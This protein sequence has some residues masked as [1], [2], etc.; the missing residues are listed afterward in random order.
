[1]LLFIFASLNAKCGTIYSYHLNAA[2]YAGEHVRRYAAGPK[3]VN[4][5]TYSSLT[6][7][8]SSSVFHCV[9]VQGG[10]QFVLYAVQKKPQKALLSAALLSPSVYFFRFPSALLLGWSLQETQSKDKNEASLFVT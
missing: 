10:H 6:I 5:Q 1:M 3:D 4:P 8:K 7:L 9:S 2:K